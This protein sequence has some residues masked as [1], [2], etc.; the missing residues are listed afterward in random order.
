MNT[1]NTIKQKARILFLLLGGLSSMTRTLRHGGEGVV[2]SMVK[3]GLEGKRVDIVVGGV[4]LIHGQL[5][6][7]VEE[8]SWTWTLEDSGS[9][10]LG[11]R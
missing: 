10:L 4:P 9:F 1:R 5:W 3:V 6:A 2:R 11:R 7:E 8:D